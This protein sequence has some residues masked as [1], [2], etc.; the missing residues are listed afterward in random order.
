MISQLEELKA[1]LTDHDPMTVLYG[2]VRDGIHGRL[3]HYRD[4]RD[5]F[6][7]TFRQLKLKNR[8]W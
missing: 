6:L 3:H 7:K 5:R 8:S 2:L 4:A 1:D